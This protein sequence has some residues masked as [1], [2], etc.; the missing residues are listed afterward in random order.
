VEG[1]VTDR[2]A[3][4][5][6]KAVLELTFRSLFIFGAYKCFGGWGCMLAVGLLGSFSLVRAPK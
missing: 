4:L 5:V 1:A 6:V 2:E 3:T